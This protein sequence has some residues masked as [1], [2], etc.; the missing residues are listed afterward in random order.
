M[1]KP[2]LFILSALLLLLL[3][4]CRGDEPKRMPDTLPDVHGYIS[5]IKKTTEKS[6][7]SKAVVLVKAI[8]GIDAPYREADIRIDKNTL[9]ENTS[10]K[11]LKLEQLREGQEVEA[12]FEGDVL[13]SMPVQG[14]VKAVRVT[15]K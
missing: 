10:G 12:W 8:E 7:N 1:K 14:Y 2:V 4:G 5:H 13:E 3:E 11:H 6:E 9:I 15:M